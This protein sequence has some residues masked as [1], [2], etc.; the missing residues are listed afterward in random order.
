MEGRKESGELYSPLSFLSAARSR[1]VG[2][3]FRP[4]GRHSRG[5]K[6]G[7]KR[8]GRQTEKETQTGPQRRF[9]SIQIDFRFASLG[10][11]QFNLTSG[12][13][14]VSRPCSWSSSRTP[15]AAPSPRAASPRPTGSESSWTHRV[16]SKEPRLRLDLIPE[17]C[18][19]PHRR[20]GV[21]TASVSLR[22][23]L[24]TETLHERR[25]GT[26]DLITAPRGRV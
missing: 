25:Q 20:V 3:R 8:P 7:P 18:K 6:C 2:I 1:S 19:Q 16:R 5:K 26:V 10:R 22:A 15:P 13:T 4:L 11:P 12:S 21:Q 23:H 17:H 14:S 24:R 9:L